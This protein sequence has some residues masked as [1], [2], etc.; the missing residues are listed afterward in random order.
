VIQIHYKRYI[1]QATD[2]AS[3][4]FDSLEDFSDTLD[5]LTHFACIPECWH[6]LAY[7][8]LTDNPNTEAKA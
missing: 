5:S 4:R 3:A 8:D 2:K 7:T 6:L 1:G